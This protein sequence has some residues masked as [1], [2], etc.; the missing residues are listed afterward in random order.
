M[1]ACYCFGWKN[2]SLVM[3]DFHNADAHKCGRFDLATIRVLYLISNT[4]K[5]LNIDGSDAYNIFL[6]HFLVV[7]LTC[8]PKAGP[9]SDMILAL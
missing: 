6:N 4:K 9:E 1:I 3:D 7:H 5:H 8:S 2:V